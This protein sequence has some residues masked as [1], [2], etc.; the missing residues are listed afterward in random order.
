MVAGAKPAFLEF[1][2]SVHFGASEAAK[3]AA[4][5]HAGMAGMAGMGMGAGLAAAGSPSGEPKW[6]AP[7]NWT[8]PRPARW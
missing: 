8:K 4:D 3:P 6:N 1:L 7:A 5:P 2:K